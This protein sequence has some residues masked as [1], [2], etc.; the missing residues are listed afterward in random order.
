MQDCCEIV[1]RQ[2]ESV[3]EIVR[4][5]VIVRDSCEK[6]RECVTVK[7]MVRDDFFI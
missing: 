2:T 4:E 5:C 3:C 6:V 7:D 1:V